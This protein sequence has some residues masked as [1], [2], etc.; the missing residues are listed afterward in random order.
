M[1]SFAP[2]A[3]SDLPVP[4][5]LLEALVDAFGPPGD[6]V[7]IGATARDLALQVGSVQLPRRATR[8]V[9][10]AVAAH[11]SRDFQRTLDGVGRPTAAW[12]RRVV[13]GH[14]VDVVPFGDLERHGEVVVQDSVLNVLGLSE[15]AAHAD[16]LVL[17]SGRV[18]PVAPLELI[19]ILKMVAFADRYPGESRD[20]EDLRIVLQAASHGR[21]GD[22][23]WDDDDALAAVGFDHELAGAYRLGRRGL[24]CFR[25]DRASMVLSVASRTEDTLQFRGHRER[26][27][28]LDAWRAGLRDAA[29]KDEGDGFDE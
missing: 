29:S 19:A 13:L 23:V 17:P 16:R 24:E 18:L 4:A 7:V 21:Y 12:Q 9:D 6:W 8:D 27:V 15:A 10:I 11:D 26:R 25:P 22:E 5:V 3:D 20:A 1:R 14:Q 2:L 28:L